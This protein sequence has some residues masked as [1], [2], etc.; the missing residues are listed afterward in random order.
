M[1]EPTPHQPECALRM[2]ACSWLSL[3]RSDRLRGTKGRVLLSAEFVRSKREESLACG[4]A[5]PYQGSA[6]CWSD[7]QSKQSRMVAPYFYLL[8]VYHRYASRRRRQTTTP[9]AD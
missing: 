3:T 4:W 8:L 2:T 7:P 9:D 1:R 5:Y 6:N